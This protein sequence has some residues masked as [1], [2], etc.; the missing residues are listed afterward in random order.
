MA[1]TQYPI[2]VAVTGA[3]GRV[4]YAL[5]FRIASGA[6]FGP[7]QPVHL[8]LIEIPEA[9][10]VLKGVVMELEDCAFP[11]LRGMTAT[12]SLE[13][14]F[15]GAHWVFLVGAIH[16][17][18]TMK[19]TDWIKSNAKVY[20]DQGRVIQNHSAF[21][22]RVVV[23][24]NPCNTNCWAA[25]QGAPD[26]PDNRWFALTALDAERASN[27]LAKKAGVHASLVTNL[28]VWGN[29][30]SIYPDFLNAKI[31]G[32]SAV[33]VIHDI[34][35]MEKD[36]L[37]AIQRRRSDIINLRKG[38]PAASVANAVV[39]TVRFVN[40]PQDFSDW[41]SVAIPSDGSYNVDKGLV[42]S[43]PIGRIGNE[44]EIVP[45]IRFNDFSRSKIKATIDD[46]KQE[47]DIAK[48][49]INGKR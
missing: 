23:I 19:K 49:A 32:K 16:L 25:H 48:K 41:F 27:Q 11:L 42:C 7:H 43:V 3:A 2:R 1:P 26:I 9:Q 15:R 30:T 46:L 34:P 29:H 28:A 44:W 6:M 17:G 20:Y 4:A 13:E 40:D 12:A 37:E 24:G 5:L 22:V 18:D 8:S 35:W 14:G 39:N 10:E 47:R 38:P 36:F 45:N 21:D 31:N 33:D